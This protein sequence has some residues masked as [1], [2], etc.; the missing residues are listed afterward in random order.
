MKKLSFKKGTKNFNMV[1]EF[2][3]ERNCYVMNIHNACSTDKTYYFP[4]GEILDTNEKLHYIGKLLDEYNMMFSYE[5]GSFETNKKFMTFVNKF[6]QE[7]YGFSNMDLIND[8][9]KAND[10]KDCY[11]RV[12]RLYN[13]TF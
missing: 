1:I 2:N 8:T 7:Y 5:H 6:V 3:E 12:T 9:A 13:F 10:L 11:S 4:N